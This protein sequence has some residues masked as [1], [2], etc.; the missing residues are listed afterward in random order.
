M[1]YSGQGLDVLLNGPLKQLIDAG[2]TIVL[3]VD[4][5]LK[6]QQ[7]LKKYP[8]IEVVF[9]RAHL[10]KNVQGRV[11]SMLEA[12][13]YKGDGETRIGN[14][15]FKK[16]CDSIKTAQLD[17]AHGTSEEDWTE[18]DVIKRM[19]ASVDH[20]AGEISVHISMQLTVNRNTR[21]L[22]GKGRLHKQPR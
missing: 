18:E 8:G 4:G 12:V 10:K 3:S 22:Q 20:Y 16:L 19:S 11:K 1:I 21:Q 13:D 2:F 6:L 14:D 7:K 9:D 15:N 17:C 5:D